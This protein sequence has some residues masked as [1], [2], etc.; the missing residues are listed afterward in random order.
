MITMSTTTLMEN[1]PDALFNSVTPLHASIYIY[2]FIYLV[3]LLRGFH[4][5]LDAIPNTLCLLLAWNGKSTICVTF[6]LQRYTLCRPVIVVP[7]PQASNIRCPCWAKGLASAQKIEYTACTRS[8]SAP[9]LALSLPRSPARSNYYHA[10]RAHGTHAS[11]A[12]EKSGRKKARRSGR[13][14]WVGQV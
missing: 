2:I 11:E 12:P 10:L 8:A 9:A 6:A 5:I 1:L 14:G 7:T 3:L 13:A 4:L